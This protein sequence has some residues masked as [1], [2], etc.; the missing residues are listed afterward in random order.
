MPA[1]SR[2]GE[3]EGIDETSERWT[4]A[5]HEAAHAVIAHA[6][7]AQVTVCE[8]DRRHDDRGRTRHTAEGP[9]WA[10]VAVAGERA[11]RQLLGAGGGSGVDYQQADA[12]LTGTG[13]DIGWAEHAA[14]ELIG[15]HR[16][17]ITTLARQLYRTGH[18]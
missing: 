11:T 5:V 15:T 16:R 2:V 9:D 17:D 14:D 7:G 18:R 6:C 1:R 4:T 8:I 3:R 13:R 10:V 12:A